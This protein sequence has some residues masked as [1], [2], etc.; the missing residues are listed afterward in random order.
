[1]TRS[2]SNR[3]NA[4]RL[5]LAILAMLFLHERPAVSNPPNPHVLGRINVFRGD[6]IAAQ[7][8]R[9]PKDVVLRR[10]VFENPAV[11][12]EGKGRVVGIVLVADTNPVREAFQLVSTRWDFCGSPGCRGDWRTAFTFPLNTRGGPGLRLPKGDYRLYLIADG[13]PV[14]VTLRLNGLTGHKSFVLTEPATGRVASPIETLSTPSDYTFFGRGKS[15]LMPRPGLLMDGEEH[16]ISSGAGSHQSCYWR[17]SEEKSEI[18]STPGPH[19][20]AFAERGTRG[21]SVAVGDWRVR[22]LGVS[23]VPRG[24]WQSSYWS[25]YVSPSMRSDFLALW[26]A[27]ERP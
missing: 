11:A 20:L 7:M 1:M 15:M 2:R 17:G 14:R 18:E 23:L 25:T 4:H 27:Y 5:L 9:I 10:R 26:L 13:A 24:D 12:Y 22:G 19:C 8:V 6:E 3:C 21:E 16:S